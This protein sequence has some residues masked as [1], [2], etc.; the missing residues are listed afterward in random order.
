MFEFSR[1]LKITSINVVSVA[2]ALT[3]KFPHSLWHLVSDSNSVPTRGFRY[4]MRV[5]GMRPVYK[6]VVAEP[7]DPSQEYRLLLQAGSTK[8]Q[9]D[10]DLK[11]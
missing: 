9:H 1:K 3:N 6:G 7:L 5:P 2:D 8:V 11:P 10:F 4:G